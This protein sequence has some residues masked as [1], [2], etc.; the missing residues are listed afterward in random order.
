M[1][2][3]G[4]V[5]YADPVRASRRAMCASGREKSEGAPLVLW[6]TA[7]V[8]KSSLIRASDNVRDVARAGV[9][10]AESESRP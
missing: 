8:D 9:V 4:P 10:E 1:G 6:G 3:A 7:D 5:D 2:F